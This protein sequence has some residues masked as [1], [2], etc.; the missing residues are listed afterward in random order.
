MVRCLDVQRVKGADGQMLGWSAA[1]QGLIASALI[2]R[3]SGGHM[4][5]RI[6]GTLIAAFIVMF[7]T[8]C[9]HMSYYGAI[10]QKLNNDTINSNLLF[11]TTI[12]PSLLK[13]K[14]VALSVTGNDT[15]D[16]VKSRFEELMLNHGIVFCAPATADYILNVRVDVL[17]TLQDDFGLQGIYYN[18][19]RV[20]ENILS[21]NLYDIN[22]NKI[23]A[24]DRCSS[25]SAWNEI[26][27]LCFGPFRDYSTS[28]RGYTYS[29]AGQ[30]ENTNGTVK[31]FSANSPALYS[32]ITYKNGKPDGEAHWYYPNGRIKQSVVYRLG[33]VESY[34]NYSIDGNLVEDR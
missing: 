19:R 25:V 4:F 29:E 16:V 17:N 24:S 22:K 21:M 9:A 2:A 31:T 33:V 30:E 3:T 26:Y 11:N 6:A 10:D 34:K 7:L 8:G 5:K 32:D 18:S 13:A 23:I 1:Q 12:T 15:N 14:K 20:G 28:G 27:V